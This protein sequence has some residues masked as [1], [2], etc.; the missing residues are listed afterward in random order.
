MTEA[1]VIST[2]FMGLRRA[3]NIEAHA[4]NS[5]TITIHA[6]EPAPPVLRWRIGNRNHRRQ[7]CLMA[8]IG[9]AVYLYKH[10]AVTGC[11]HE[12]VG[13][14]SVFAMPKLLK[15]YGLKIDCFFAWELSEAFARPA[16]FCRNHLGAGSNKHIV[17]IGRISKGYAR[18][19]DNYRCAS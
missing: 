7:A 19:D 12:A 17:A 16:T 4:K 8:R 6:I 1:A 9:F 2:A 13:D 14:G 11:P 3:F 15:N 10:L 5:T 18:I